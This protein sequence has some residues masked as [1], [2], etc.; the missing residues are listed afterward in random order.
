M[1]L[2][3]VDSMGGHGPGW[4]EFLEIWTELKNFGF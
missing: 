4:S 3:D 2:H 1:G